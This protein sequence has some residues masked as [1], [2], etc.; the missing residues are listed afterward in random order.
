MAPLIPVIFLLIGYVSGS[1]PWGL[2]VVR[3]MTG[4][5]IRTVGSGRTGGTNA[6]RAAGPVAF[7]LVVLLDGAKGLLPVIAARLLFPDIPLAAAAAGIGAVA[8]TIWSVFI[9]FK[10]GAGGVTNMGV[11]LGLSP[12]AAIAAIVL[13]LGA[14][15]GARMASV[16]TLTGSA[17]SLVTLILLAWL[18]HS[19]WEYV[20]YGI[21]Q[22]IFVV[23]ALRPNIQRIRN[24]TER[25]ID[26]SSFTSRKAHPKG[27]P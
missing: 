13:G 9:H 2:V 7:A 18:G 19:P 17:T 22:L 14:F 16:G 24:G 12:I 4:Q 1:I 5:D 25:R 11:T 8:G 21:A 20:L 3:L 15:I 23:I 26:L 6:L 27:R 10:G